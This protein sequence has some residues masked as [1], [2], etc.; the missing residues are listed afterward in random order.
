MAGGKRLVSFVHVSDPENGPAV[1]GPDD[2]VPAWA[3]KLITNP[4]AWGEAPQGQKK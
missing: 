2:D 1:F 3:S 4:K